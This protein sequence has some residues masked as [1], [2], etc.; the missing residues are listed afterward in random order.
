[1][2][3]SNP[4]TPVYTF[5]IFMPEVCISESWMNVN[6][7]YVIGEELIFD[8]ESEDCPLLEI[9]VEFEDHFLC[10]FECGIN[11]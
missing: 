2:P 3:L 8:D 5:Y 9:F 4:T 11:W 1:M 7:V 6:I 10:C